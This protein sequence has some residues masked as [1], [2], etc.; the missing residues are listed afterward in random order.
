MNRLISKISL[1]LLFGVS[2]FSFGISTKAE[3]QAPILTID[4]ET[5]TMNVGEQL[6]LSTK[7]FSYVDKSDLIW[8][9][10]DNEVIYFVEDYFM[11]YAT[12]AGNIK[13]EVSNS[14]KTLESVFNIT[15]TATNLYPNGDFENFQVGT[16]WDY[17]NKVI[18]NWR[19][20]TANAAIKQ[21]QVVDI[22]Q[23]E[24]DGKLSKVYHASHSELAY[25]TLYYD[26]PVPEDGYYYIELDIKGQGLTNN[27]YARINLNEPSVTQT[28][29]MKGTF[30]WTRFT[31]NIV[32]VT[33]GALRV[34]L[35][36]ANFQG[37]VW[38]D[39]ISVYK[40]VKSDY[41]NYELNT[42][43]IS[44]HVG[45]T[46][47][48]TP[49][50]DIMTPIVFAY[51]YEIDDEVIASV[52]KDGLIQ[53]LTEG[54]TT[55]SII[56]QQN[57]REKQLCV[58]VSNP[59]VFSTETF[60]YKVD[61][62]KTLEA[63]L[64]GGEVLIYPY[65]NPLY[66]DYHIDQNTI[67]YTPNYN[68]NSYGNPEALAIYDTFK[69]IFYEAGVGFQI[70][71]VNIE[72]TPVTDA[73]E[74]IDFWHST[75]KNQSLTT[76]YLEVFSKDIETFIKE[77]N[78]NLLKSA[79]LTDGVTTYLDVKTER[80]ANIT[81][82]L[83]D[84]SLIGLTDQGGTVE[85][86][87]GGSVS[88]V[89]DR[90]FQVL[91][92]LKYGVHFKYT[93]KTDF[94]GYDNF[95][96]VIDNEGTVTTFEVTVY[97]TPAVEDFKFEE[98]DFTGVYVVG[99]DEWIA[100]TRQAYLEGDEVINTW[101]NNYVEKFK[102]YTPTGVP[103]KSRSTLEQLSILY[104]VTGDSYYADL[105]WLQLYEVVKDN[106]F[107]G[108]DGTKR[109]SWGKDSNGFLDAAMVTYSVAFAYNLV[110]D[111]LS[112]QQKEMVVRALYEEG[113]YW[114]ESISNVNVLLHGNNHNLL[115]NGNLAVAALAV[116]S[117]EGSI[118]MTLPDGNVEDVNIKEMAS[119][120]VSDAYKYL[121]IAFV[122]YSPSGGFPEGPAYSY[123]GH[124]TII[125]LMAT[126]KN[127]YGSE[128]FEDIYD[129]GLNQV[130][131]VKNYPEYVLYTSTPNY[132][133]F[134][135]NEGGYN[136][137]QPG[138]LWYARVDERYKP[139]V[140]INKMAYEYEVY[141]AV[142]LLWYQPGMFDSL[143]NVEDMP[144]DALF[145]VHEMATFRNRFNDDSGFFSA[146][147][148]FDPT[149]NLFTHKSLDSGTF[150]L[151]V[152]GEKFIQNFSNEN[153]SLSVPP[154]YWDYESGRW[155]YYRKQP[156]GHNLVVFNPS[157]HPNIQQDPGEK[158]PIVE[159]KS[160]S[161]HGYSI[162][163]L[164]KVYNEDVISYNRGMFFD[165]VGN[166]MVLQDE[167][168]LK[169]SSELYWAAH[170][171]GSIDIITPKVASITINNKKVYVV[172]ESDMGT[173]SYDYARALPGTS[174]LFHNLNND[175]INKLLIHVTDVTEGVISVKFLP[176]LEDMSAY[177]TR[178]V[179]LLDAW[180]DIKEVN[181]TE[182]IYANDI[183]FE[184]V[185]GDKYLYQFVPTKYT[186]QVKLDAVEQFVPRLNVD[187]DK[188][189]YSLEVI[190]SKVFT[191]PSKVIIKDKATGQS[192]TYTYQ[193]IVDAFVD[194][195]EN[196]LKHD[197][198]KVTSTNQSSINLI[199]DD[200][201][202]FFEAL[203]QETVIFEFAEKKRI[204][205]VSMRFS[206]GATY[207]YFFDIYAG[208]D[209]DDMS[210]V[211][212]GG[213][214]SYLIGD[215]YMSLGEIKAK[216]IKVVFKGNTYNHEIKL[217]RVNFYDNQ[218]ASKYVDENGGS[219]SN[220]GLIIGVA[221][222]SVLMVATGVV[223]IFKKKTGR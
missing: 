19:I 204:T 129:F 59:H 216:Y 186:Y 179:I 72:V 68:F 107:A 159:F 217:S 111:T 41:L 16:T 115:I 67:I 42:E 31:S 221:S 200:R 6:D 98:A 90:Y 62:D 112:E 122:H 4:G 49:S 201:Q 172:I 212:F 80:Y 161:S 84:G 105:T 143:G 92:T 57:K 173:F 192:V 38:F 125:G 116:M 211:Y 97:V 117:Y 48:I 51:D 156:Q 17:T 25:S 70:V 5:I 13:V 127:I 91:T 142:S 124:K 11:V 52:T 165:R 35:Y 147:K 140:L 132:N 96:M 15:V 167:F 114:F 66:G 110:Y 185:T 146:L 65:S 45:E 170:T 104:Q 139:Y 83:D 10:K 130:L 34:E 188:T 191:Q 119:K 85:I 135:F 21:G 175:S 3:E 171:S 205:N 27:V 210:L 206:G 63:D 9:I 207:Q 75:P 73:V 178:E 144:Y 24:R 209:L 197:V 141:T 190:N 149:S 150:E 208:N 196:M 109:A 189:K 53:G 99:N 60:D 71:D 36:G 18:N 187:Y 121:Q 8:I 1:I 29:G 218:Q 194:P 184:A 102:V 93:P 89:K 37:E 47:Q 133:T 50:V 77:Q 152:F 157:D 134:Y 174:G 137:D 55:L 162:L 113:F 118:S 220:L 58:V 103:A 2:V 199:D 168:K 153:Y 215:E 7:I 44:L 219:N 32:E 28:T 223:F 40:V 94:V 86:L 100:E 145:E 54:I 30:D 108:G 79:K 26:I 198:S 20:Y 33:D 78:L 74:V 151:E 95:T 193:F 120:V 164:S 160:L 43:F 195:F 202:T 214:S 154:G 56:D 61:E 166:Y 82:S 158:A 88:Q 169:K 148:G 182:G 23:V 69:V 203:D 222:L 126:L 213:Q 39:N 12:R 180:K 22:V 177:E 64:I 136:I 46:F 14:D 81:G 123:Y 128:G 176:S 131:G 106:T 87:Y 76:G 183:S 138:M 101:V 163:D 181:L 155:Q